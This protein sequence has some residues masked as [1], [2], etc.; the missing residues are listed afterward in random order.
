MRGGRLLGSGCRASAPRSS[1]RSCARRREMA[2]RNLSAEVSVTEETVTAGTRRAH[3]RP[4]G[5][6]PRRQAVD[7]R[8]PR[9]PRLR[10][11]RA[12]AGRHARGSCSRIEPVAVFYS[13]GPGDPAASD[14][15][16]ALLRG[17]L[18]AGLPFFGICFG[19][20]LLGRALGLGTYKLPFG[21]RGINQPVLDKTH[22]ARRDHLAQ[23]R[24]RGRRRR[25]RAC[26]TARTATAGSRS[27]TSA[28]T[29][30]SSRGCARLDIPAFSVQYH[31]EAAAGP[32]DANYLFDR[33]A[34]P[35]ASTTIADEGATT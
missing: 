6:R 24:L 17:V 2:G 12:A 8:Q 27:A 1:S 25:S 28:S 15:H 13:N 21:H 32:H 11:A 16:V 35:G 20:Q 26:S 22:R 31:P 14:D 7:G 29:T 4:R 9:R 18:D 19:N 5:A 34:R 33:F 3:R 10:R 23:P 30:T